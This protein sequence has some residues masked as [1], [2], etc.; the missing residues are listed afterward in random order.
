[1]NVELFNKFKVANVLILLKGKKAEQNF[2]PSSKHSK[3]YFVFS[4][5]VNYGLAESFG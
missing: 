3:F 5:W 4:V 2:C 1:M